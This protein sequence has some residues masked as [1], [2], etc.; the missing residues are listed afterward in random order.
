ML[1][2]ATF[3]TFPKRTQPAL[4]L[5]IINRKLEYEILQAPL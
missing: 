4:A 2:L 5:A 3:K 1:K